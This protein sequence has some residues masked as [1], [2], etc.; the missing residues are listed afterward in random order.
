M[1]GD[2]RCLGPV[3]ILLGTRI[4]KN[5]IVTLFLAWLIVGGTSRMPIWTKIPA[6]IEE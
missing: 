2:D 4:K 5:L 3:D 6:I 1:I